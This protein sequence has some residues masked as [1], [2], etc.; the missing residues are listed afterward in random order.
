MKS[1]SD[2]YIVPVMMILLLNDEMLPSMDAETFNVKVA[3]T[4]EL[5]F[6]AVPFWFHVKVRY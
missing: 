5:A 1:Q 3:C 2:F 4:T 6:S